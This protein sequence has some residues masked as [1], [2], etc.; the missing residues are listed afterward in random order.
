MSVDCQV[1]K[2]DVVDGQS[3][4]LSIYLCTISPEFLASLLSSY[5][6]CS[7]NHVNSQYFVHFLTTQ[8]Q[9]DKEVLVSFDVVPLF[10]HML[11]ASAAQV[12]HEW[13]DDTSLPGRITLT[14]EDIS[15]RLDSVLRPRIHASKADNIRRYIARPWGTHLSSGCQLGDGRHRTSTVNV[16]Y[17]HEAVVDCMCFILN[18]TVWITFIAPVTGLTA[19][20]SLWWNRLR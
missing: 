4:F 18:A 2:Q 8:K 7:D 5:V 17:L 3:S 14:V 11:T 20:F 19:T 9:R 15:S 16:S 6:G 1:H 12:I 10:T 13:P